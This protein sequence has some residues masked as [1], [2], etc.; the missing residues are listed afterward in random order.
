ML[1]DTSRRSG[2]ATAI[3]RS[4]WP[5]ASLT[6]KCRATYIPPERSGVRELVLSVILFPFL[7]F[8]SFGGCTSAMSDAIGEA[9]CPDQGQRGYQEVGRRGGPPLISLRPRRLGGCRLWRDAV[10]NNP[11][12][13]GTCADSARG[14]PFLYSIVS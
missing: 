11:P 2:S 6:R 12:N 10:V 1:T 4:A 9:T 8:P 14:V 13:R 7:L 5:C 3:S